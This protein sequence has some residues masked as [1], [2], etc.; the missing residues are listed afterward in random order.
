[1][2][3]LVERSSTNSSTVHLTFDP[4]ETIT[5]VA[6]AV[7]LAENA[8]SGA[9]GDA[10]W[11]HGTD[12]HRRDVLERRGFTSNRTLL[13]MRRPLPADS[14]DL[15]TR[16]FTEDDIDAFVGVNN[17]AF[18]W[19]PEQSGLTA[20]AVRADMAADWFDADGFRLHH[21][22]GELAGFCWT[23]IHTEPE[24]LGEIYVIAVDPAF[25]GRG[26]GKAMTLAGLQW[27]AAQGLMIGML[28]VESDNEAAV[29]TYR[30]IGFDVHRYD[31]MWTR[32]DDT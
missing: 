5:T 3:F 26:L 32:A 17:R 7:A 1:M 6:D 14:V 29:A 4:D 11:L 15:E 16:A 25:H 18:H 30:K 13:Q 22:D 24:R 27:L 10:I 12:D 2:E 19:H 9:P 8:L 21:I 20:E 31:T 23:K 28:Y